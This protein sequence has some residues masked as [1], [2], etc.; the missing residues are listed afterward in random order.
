MVIAIPLYQVVVTEIVAK[1]PDLII[2]SGPKNY[3]KMIER[4]RVLGLVEAN[5]RK[6]ALHKARVMARKGGLKT[7]KVTVKQ[8]HDS[9]SLTYG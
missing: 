7:R 5:D 1:E 2:S 9:S 3:Y 4:D 6:T 8:V